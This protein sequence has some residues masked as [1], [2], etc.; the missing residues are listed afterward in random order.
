MAHS[1]FQRERA[2]DRTGGRCHLCYADLDFRL[3][4]ARAHLGGWEMEH[5]RSRA[6]GGTHH[7]NN[8]YAACVS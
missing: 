1:L 2:F 5:S 8:L 3:Y 4:G 6:A 7:P